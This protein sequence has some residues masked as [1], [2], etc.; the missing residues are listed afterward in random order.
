MQSLRWGG[1]D[2][3]GGVGGVVLNPN[4]VSALPHLLKL[5]LGLEVWAELDNK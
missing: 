5:M 1:V 3:S 2:W 4:L